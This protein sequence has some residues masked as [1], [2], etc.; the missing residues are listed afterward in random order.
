MEIVTRK[1][2]ME[3]GL[4]KYFTGKLCK[5]G[6]VAERNMAGGCLACGREASKAR[7]SES[8]KIRERKAA[9]ARENREKIREINAKRYRENPEKQREATLK[10]QKANPEKAREKS[11]KWNRDNPE[12]MR[13]LKE[14]W[15]REN[16]GK[17]R[18]TRARWR[19]ENPEKQRAKEA[20]RRSQKL[21]AIPSWANKD[22]ILQ[23]YQ[24]AKELDH[25]VDHIVP[26]KSKLVCGLH[27]E[28]NLQT[29]APLEN[30]LKG[31]RYWP[32]MP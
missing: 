2:A 6:H 11:A 18:E 20:S 15:A 19:K 24:R 23:I 32:D 17:E 5:N 25:H 3:R 27:C 14:K 29:L 13:A 9:W 31:N 26:L 1:E 4:K 10:W 12:K 22:A 8:P 30:L 28:A 7:Y 16:P 21:K